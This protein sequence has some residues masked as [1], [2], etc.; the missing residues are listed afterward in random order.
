M[1]GKGWGGV[2]KDMAIRIHNPYYL[3]ATWTR[4]TRTAAATWTRAAWTA[5]ATW[6]WT[7]AWRWGAAIQKID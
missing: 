6:T 2:I 7:T 4:A 3:P 5:A 1:G